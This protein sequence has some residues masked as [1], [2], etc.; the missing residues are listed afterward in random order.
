MSKLTVQNT[1]KRADGSV[2]P[3][4]RVSIKLCPS[5]AFYVDGTTEIAR[6]VLTTTNSSGVWSIQ[7]EKNTDIVPTG[8]WYEI[9][10]AVAQADG[11]PRTWIIHV[12]GSVT[13]LNLADIIMPELP[14][15]PAKYPTYPPFVGPDGSSLR[16]LN[17]EAVWRERVDFDDVDPSTKDPVEKGD[18]WVN[19]NNN[20]FSIW[21]GSAWVPVSV[22]GVTD[23][24][25]LTGL[26]DD[27]H[28]QYYN[29]ARGDARYSQVGHT[30]T[31]SQSHNSPDTDSAPTALHHTLGTGANQAAPGN[32]SHPAADHGTLTGLTDDDH[33][34]YHT[35]ARGDARYSQLSHVHPVFTASVAGFVPLSG[36]GTANFLRADG[37]WAAP[38]GGGGGVTDHGA[39]T[40]LSDDDHTQYHTDARGDSRY[41]QLGHNHAGVYE[42]TGNLSA[43]LTDTDDAHD[44]SAIS[45]VAGGGIAATTVQ[46]AIQ[47]LDSEKAATSHTHTQ[48]QSHN[49]PD[50]DSAPTALHHT[51]GT[52]ANQAA[53]GNHTHA[54]ADHGTLTGLSDDDH[55]QYHTDARG[56]ARYVLS[57]TNRK[58][59][60]GTTAPV[61]PATGDIWLDTN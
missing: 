17:G 58:I 61:G 1:L 57:T 54:A 11:G 30:H 27:D 5:N 10:E 8:T 37:T 16:V 39:L 6:T 38:P 26:T 35:D 31:Q 13:P 56:D 53:A 34:Q 9:H 41:S 50:T 25:L 44:A 3:N 18:F 22:P 36:G 4:V 59:T 21:N 42:P 32:H 46:A 60:S 48:S 23:H 14:D 33:T 43:H 29:Q 24:G 40:G 47:E 7:L 15:D 55:T 28:G 45:Y 2:V 12:T 19:T 49:S 52:G 20:S 51:L